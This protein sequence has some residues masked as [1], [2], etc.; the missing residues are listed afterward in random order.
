MI[1]FGYFK[2]VDASYNI[3]V[4]KGLFQPKKPLVYYIWNME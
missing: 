1:I 3:T 2:T 4:K